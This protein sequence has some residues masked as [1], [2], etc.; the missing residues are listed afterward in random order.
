MSENSSRAP[1]LNWLIERFDGHEFAPPLSSQTE[2]SDVTERLV[3]LH[4]E[5]VNQSAAPQ[6]QKNWQRFPRSRTRRQGSH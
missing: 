2:L 6:W 1:L 3:R 5:S 4:L